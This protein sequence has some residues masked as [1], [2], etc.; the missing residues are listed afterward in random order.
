MDVCLLLLDQSWVLW[1]PCLQRGRGNVVLAG[2]VIAIKIG[3]RGVKEGNVKSSKITR[4]NY[5]RPPFFFTLQQ[6][7]FIK[8]GTKSTHQIKKEIITDRKF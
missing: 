1:G 4:I 8:Q 3:C 7:R 5:R 6:R 2:Y